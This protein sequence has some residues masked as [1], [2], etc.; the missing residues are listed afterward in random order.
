[1]YK[2][3]LISLNNFKSM[4]DMFRLVR[5]L[6]R[7]FNSHIVGLY[8]IPPVYFVSGPYGIGGGAQYADL[9]DF[10]LSK[11]DEIKA[12]FEDFLR[13]ENIQGEWRQT[14]T[15]GSTVAD[16]IIAHGQQSDLIILG[17][18]P[19]SKDTAGI[20]IELT[21]RVIIESG[22]PVFVT[23]KL[24]AD[25]KLGT[26]LIGWDTSKE[27]TRA[28]FDALPLLQQC[29]DVVLLRVNPQKDKSSAGD[30]PG[31]DMATALARHDVKVTTNTKTTKTSIGKALLSAAKDHDFLVMGGYGH[32]RLMERLLG[33]ATRD[34]LEHMTLPVLMAN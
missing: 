20:D 9:R 7:K 1:M 27:S 3:I 34:A 5:P 33:G 28:T 12:Q 13:A 32:S 16:T 11:A 21:A 31:A 19:P 25:F 26:A 24:S 6:A 4:D 2:T 15:H 17:H 8:V 23:P 10:Y 14:S 18:R 22:R 29:K 30:L